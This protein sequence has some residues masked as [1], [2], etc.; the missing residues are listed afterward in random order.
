MAFT[1]TGHQPTLPELITPLFRT[2]HLRILSRQM[3]PT[4]T[5]PTKKTWDAATKQCTRRQLSTTTVSSTHLLLAVK[6]PRVALA[7]LNTQKP[8]WKSYAIPCINSLQCHLAEMQKIAQSYRAR[9]ME[10]RW[11]VRDP[12]S[13]PLTHPTLTSI[14]PGNFRQ[15]W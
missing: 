7:T 12:T 10:L 6:A 13:L 5:T 11:E 15:S 3:K 9:T 4:Q 14:I 8:A 1:G 2:D